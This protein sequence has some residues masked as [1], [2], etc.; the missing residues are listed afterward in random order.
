MNKAKFTK[1]FEFNTPSWDEIIIDLDFSYSK[2]ELVKNISPGFWVCHNAWRIPRI[3]YIL[4][5]LKLK[6]AHLY[7]NLLGN[8]P[9][10]GPHSDPVDVWFWQVKGST[11]WIIEDKEEYLL[12]EGDL[13]YVPKNTLHNVIPLGP[14]AGISMSY[15]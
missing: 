15:E 3:Q 14:R 1:N 5:K 10:F 7:M 4:K 11:K 13:I 2:K 9:T 12:E 6:H 8:T